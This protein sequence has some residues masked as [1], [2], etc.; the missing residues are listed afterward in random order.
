MAATSSPNRA[1]RILMRKDV[2]SGLVFAGIAILAL[3]LGQNFRIGTA[4]RMGTGYVPRLVAYALL[5]LG[6]LTLVK[7]LITPEEDDPD[8][9][10]IA[11]R[12]LVAITG[13]ILAFGFALERLGLVVTIL[14]VVG[15][16]S[17]AV[18]GQSPWR[19]L[20]AGVVLAVTSVLVFVYGLS[21]TMPVW[22]VL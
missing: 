8:A 3:W 2:L 19:V 14:I 6:L 9:A 5:G 4:V 18:P 16:G 21:L 15:I 12:A 22:P 11:W 20:A 13:S 17:I 1:L 7:G 10:P